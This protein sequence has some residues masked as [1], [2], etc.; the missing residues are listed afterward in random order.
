MERQRA[1]EEE[2]EEEEAAKGSHGQVMKKTSG[3]HGREKKERQEVHTRNCLR[4]LRG[5][6]DNRI[7]H[8]DCL[9]RTTGF[10]KITC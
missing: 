9:S 1:N 10:S 7:N 2:E 8:F 5:A 4:K 3:W 6:N